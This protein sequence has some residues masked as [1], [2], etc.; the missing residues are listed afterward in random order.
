MADR[1]QQRLPFADV[2]NNSRASRL[3]PR[4]GQ[5]TAPLPV[6]PARRRPRPGDDDD[7]EDEGEDLFGDDIWA[8]DM[9]DMAAGQ[10]DE[11]ESDFIGTSSDSDVDDPRK[12]RIGD[13]IISRHMA[14]M[15]RRA[16]EEDRTLDRRAVPSV[17][18]S[19]PSISGASSAA[20]DM[21]DPDADLDDD[22]E[23]DLLGR[24]ESEDF[25]EEEENAAGLNLTGGPGDDDDASSAASE[26]DVSSIDASGDAIDRARDVLDALDALPDAT[27]LREALL[28]DD[29]RRAVTIVFLD[30]LL[31]P[32]RGDAAATVR[33]AAAKG[34]ESI[35]VS[36]RLLLEASRFLARALFHVPLSVLPL[37]H[38]TVTVFARRAGFAAYVQAL[39]RRRLS[40][41]FIDLPTVD[42]VRDLRI[43]HLNSFV[44]VVGVVT[45]R[46][47]VY[48]QLSEVVFFCLSCGHT[49][50]PI[51]IYGTR[52]ERPRRCPECQGGGPFRMHT[53]K[54]VYRNYQ[55]CT[56]QEPPG[57]VPP[58]RLPR[59]LEVTLSD[60]LADTCRPGQLAEIV[61]VYMQAADPSANA[62][63]GFP[64]FGT[65][66]EANNVVPVTE[67][68]SLA[69]APAERDAILALAKDDN[70][71]ELVVAS[72]APAVYGMPDVK[73]G[74]ALALFG[75][76]PKGDRRSGG[77]RSRGDINILLLGDPG[78]AKSQ[79]LKF[80]E[81][82]A[83][84]AM[85]TTGRG[86][87]AVGLTAAVQR[88]FETGEWALEGGALVLAD[89]GVCLIDEFDKMAENDR[90]AIHEAME[91]QTISV[92]KAGIVTT[93]SA[94]C[95]VIAA[96]NP[97]GGRYDASKPLLDNVDLSLPILSRF[98]LVFVIRDASSP[99]ADAALAEFVVR[100]HSLHHPD[101]PPADLLDVIATEKATALGSGGG[102]SGPSLHPPGTTGGTSGG[103]GPR[104]GGADGGGG[105]AGIG[106]VIQ[107][108]KDLG[109]EGAEVDVSDMTADEIVAAV[110]ARGRI[111]HTLLRKYLAY[112]RAHA[113]P[114][115]TYLDTEHLARLYAVLREEGR[116][117]ATPV[118]VRH[119]ESII[120]LAEARA[121]MHL[122]SDVRADDFRVAVGVFLR[123]FL[124]CQKQ[125][126]HAAV[127]GRFAPFLATA[128]DYHPVVLHILGEQLARVRASYEDMDDPAPAV[129]R[130]PVATL[131]GAVRAAL[132]PT[133]LVEFLKSS[134]FT[135]VRGAVGEV[136]YGYVWT[137]FEV[138]VK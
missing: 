14:T 65:F 63:Q 135:K 105:D 29:A 68:R 70:L 56:V 69:L 18:G 119:L 138:D 62:R 60:D 50:L 90:S 25:D 121:R 38:H 52:E 61:G 114:R 83:D 7:D 76:Q 115:L 108:L 5:R 27:H 19:V 59:S 13:A 36:V 41:R 134:L 129:P 20:G 136:V 33:A 109:G 132:G 30:T 34:A 130:L 111:P 131:A 28:D 24:A 44:R 51:K 15:R 53:T 39:P 73:L 82:T 32:P 103:G 117:G 89:Q 47:P 77:H 107:M 46:S 124:K 122:R 116:L 98:D 88:D 125:A 97:I 45:R 64:V 112:A 104:D 43:Q 87:T 16:I 26:S 96:A 79:L 94:R 85:F 2:A 92:S 54:T 9:A 126:S 49:L 10:D 21:L 40:C 66:L 3:A 101:G 106:A 78:C 57:D 4:R 74:L 37:F 93:L 102:V 72:L 48:S 133:R 75:G 118:S 67:A 8:E 110:R 17:L 100:S 81:R 86:S 1:R 120:R 22:D 127:L 12:R 123:A 137:L 128:A 113:H 55:S 6:R 99:A 35:E 42:A 71:S 84:R 31:H 91:Q 23:V 58:G 80:V 95:S 11:Y